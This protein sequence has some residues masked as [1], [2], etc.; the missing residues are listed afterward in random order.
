MSLSREQ[1]KAMQPPRWATLARKA[2]RRADALLHAVVIAQLNADLDIKA[3]RDV[4]IAELESAIYHERRAAGDEHKA[5]L[6]KSRQGR[7]QVDTLAGWA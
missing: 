7:K 6:D 5:A 1:L 3:L 2:R 4:A